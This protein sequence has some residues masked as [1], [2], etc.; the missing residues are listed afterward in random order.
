MPPIPVSIDY[1]TYSDLD[2]TEV[3]GSVYSRDPST[4]VLMAAWQV[5]DGPMQQWVPAEGEA[6]P[7]DLAE[8]LVSPNYEKWAW[9]APFE[10]RITANT[11][12]IPVNVRQW[13]DTMVQAMHC[14]LPGSLEAAGPVLGLPDDKLKDRRG[15]TL[16]RRFSFPR[17][18]TKRDPRTR[19]YWHDDF[20]AWQEYLG[21]NRADVVAEMAIRRR[22][23]PYMMSDDE[24][25]LWFLDQEINEAGLPINRRMVRNA[26][27]VYEEALGTMDPPTGAFGEMVDI[28]GLANPNSLTQLL[29]WLRE[30]GYMFS[31]CKKGHIQT[32]LKYF[33]EKPEHWA[34]GQWFQYRS[35]NTLKR[36]LELRVETSRTSIKKYYALDRATDKDGM[37]RGC[38]Q[39]NGA[40]RTGRWGGRL[41]QPQNLPRPEKRFEDYQGVLAE[42]VEKLDLQAIRLIH[43]NPF[44]ALASALRPVAQ[45]PEGMVFVDADLSAIEN[46]V[47][48]W[49][50]GCDKILEVFRLKRDPYI[51]FATYLYEQPYD[52]LFHEYKVLKDSSKR[53]IGKPGT[54][55]AGYGMGAGEKRINRDTGE[56][57]GTGLLGYAWG[58]GVSHFTEEDAKHSIDTFRATFKEV[59]SHWYDME[60]AAKRCVRTG[61]PQESGLARFERR[62]PFLV[63]LLPSDRPVYYLRPRIESVKTPWGVDKMQLTYEGQDERKQWVRINTTPGKIVENFV[64]AIS[65]DLLAHGMKLARREGLDTRLHVHDQILALAPEDQAEEKLKVLIACMEESPS[66]ANGLPVGS[67]GH[68]TKYF[69][70]D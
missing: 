59:V 36:L 31:D 18:P 33:D 48:G 68:T 23:Y 9:N 2:L 4:E 10:M 20:P 34:E 5:D 45:A 7:D 47:L 11:L 42:G 67:N 49:T 16:M 24:W 8:M 6:I 22:L 17:K 12:R 35:S 37:L 70:K 27:Q 55:G 46:R 65:R 69:I 41:F 61:K 19:N 43:G 38:L 60:K 54:L 1:E 14:S 32:A 40:A 3:G 50:S 63:M 30:H 26:I 51:S 58:M 13:R 39:M 52:K 66:W 53:T 25:E 15:S 29:P 62:G 28:T 44:D 57:E 56:I 21:Y 64:Q